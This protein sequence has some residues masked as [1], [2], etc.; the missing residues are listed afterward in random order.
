M[1][2][3]TICHEIILEPYFYSPLFP[4]ALVSAPNKRFP[5]HSL[6]SINKALLNFSWVA[7]KGRGVTARVRITTGFYARNKNFS[8]IL[9]PLA[10]QWF[11]CWSSLF[12][13]TRFQGIGVLEGL[14]SQKGCKLRHKVVAIFKWHLKISNMRGNF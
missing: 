1:K 8:S 13:T 2:N 12:R 7:V 10:D 14:R 11:R 3:W 4:D 9:K 5:R 6:L